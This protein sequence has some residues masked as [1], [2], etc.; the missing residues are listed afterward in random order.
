ML[1]EGR[2]ET[3]TNK[4]TFAYLV[5]SIRPSKSIRDYSTTAVGIKKRRLII[6]PPLSSFLFLSFTLHK[7]IKIFLTNAELLANLLGFQCSIFDRIQNIALS[8]LHHIRGFGGSH[9]ICHL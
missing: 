8:Y 1:F 9:N 7:R 6:Q 5:V 2:I 3:I 4:N